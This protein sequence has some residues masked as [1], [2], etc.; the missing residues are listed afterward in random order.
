MSFRLKTILG[1]G[2]IEVLMLSVLVVSGLHYLR[3]SNEQQ[4]VDRADNLARLFAT[5]T[6]DAVVA[7]DLATIDVLIDEALKNRGISYVRVRHVNGKV[8]GE[9]GAET[10][11][12]RPFTPDGP[13]I[14]TDDDGLLDISHPIAIAGKTFGRI[15]LGIDVGA[16]SA[17][18]D[19]ARRWM[20]GVAGIEVL[21]VALFSYMLGTMLTRQLQLLRRGARQVA[22]GNLGYQIEVS[23]TDELAD[24]AASFNAMS[25]ALAVYSNR[26][27]EARALAEAGRARAESTLEDAIDSLSEGILIT[28]SGSRVLHMNEAFR[29]LYGMDGAAIVGAD[30]LD[31]V[32]ALTRPLIVEREVYGAETASAG[33]AP[34]VTFVLRDGRRILHSHRPIT[35]GGNV[36]INTDVTAIYASQE[37][38]RQLELKLMQAQ[39]LESLG[40]LAGGIAHEINTPIQYIGDNLRFLEQSSED[41]ATV[42]D[43]HVRLADAIAAHPAGSE[44]E[45]AT[46]V[47]FCRAVAEETDITFLAEEAPLAAR[48]SS[49]G[50]EQVAGIVR[51]MKEFSHPM[52]KEMAPLD[53]NRVI[54]RATMVCSNEWKHCAEL[55]LSLNDRLPQVPGLEG[56]LNQVVLNLVVNAAHAIVDADQGR[57]R[58]AIATGIED[59]MAVLTVADNGAGIPASVGA[60]IFE[61]FFTTKDVGKGTGQ[62]LA[63]AHDIIVTKHGGTLD[64]ETRGGEGTT[65]RVALPLAGIDAKA[66]TTGVST[67]VT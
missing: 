47:A 43:A 46:A 8:M 50:V 60:R 63:I 64:F 66:L 48:Q 14:N 40:T 57:G 2:L 3:E 27:E 35:S 34:Q 30:H 19:Q 51:A 4:M 42:I 31:A 32:K 10:F 45:I 11:L 49:E 26:L 41:F 1:I 39:K 12:R 38:A 29:G 52:S 23:G 21:V 15:E 9:G 58:I 44:P 54:E 36:F 5:M 61:P 25:S 16:I 56:E 18:Q 17:A 13:L 67:E 62:G 24:T 20:L 65:F 55:H 28:D 53:L 7:V 33:T 37:R 59:G 6:A 22:D